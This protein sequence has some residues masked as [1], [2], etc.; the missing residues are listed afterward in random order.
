MCSSL[1]TPTA[2][3]NPQHADLIT[4]EECEQMISM[5]VFQNLQSPEVICR[6]TD[7]LRRHGFKKEYKTLAGTYIDSHTLVCLLCVM[8]R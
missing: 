1:L 3:A 2:L 8:L 6:M 7:V 4:K 5:G